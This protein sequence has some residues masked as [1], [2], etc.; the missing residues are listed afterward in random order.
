MHDINYV[1]YE[2][3][4]GQTDVN[5]HLLYLSK[6]TKE[7]TSVLQCGGDH[8]SDCS[9]AFINGLV[10]N[11]KDTKVLD[12]SHVNRFHT[13]TSIQEACSENN[14][15][16]T[17]YVGSSLTL[18]EKEYDMVYISTWHVYGH[19]KRELVKFK[20]STKKYIVMHATE[21]DKTQGESVRCR[22]NIEQ[23]M[24]ESGYSLEEVTTGLQKAID[25]FLENNKDWQIKQHFQHQHGLTVLE[26]MST[27]SENV[28]V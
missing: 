9:W 6:L 26:R 21:V 22:F 8:K 28:T 16:H 19:L 2:K 18:P 20:D 4:S 11:K 27:N 1:L 5:E 14:V 13:L 25:E 23:Q 10:K 3:V 15:A 17:Y 24:K 7:C 12:I